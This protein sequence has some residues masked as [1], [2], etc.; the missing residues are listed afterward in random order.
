[1][2]HALVDVAPGR[3]RS[4]PVAAAVQPDHGQA[5]PRSR[6]R[7]QMSARPV[8]H[9]QQVARQRAEMREFESALARWAR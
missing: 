2:E 9:R 5:G 8:R 4:T 3:Q 7:L 1:M 6:S